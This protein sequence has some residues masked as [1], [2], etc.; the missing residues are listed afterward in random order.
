MVELVV[1]E[2]FV[3]VDVVVEALVE[4]LNSFQQPKQPYNNIA[5]LIDY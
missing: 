4:H 3:V 1:F 5:V 2:S